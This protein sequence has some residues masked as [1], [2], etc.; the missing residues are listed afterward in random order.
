MNPITFKLT[1]MFR[2]KARVMGLIQK[3]YNKI[4][5]TGYLL[6]YILMDNDISNQCLKKKNFSEIRPS[7]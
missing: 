5:A 2:I 3:I 1:T 7:I 4:V 6:E